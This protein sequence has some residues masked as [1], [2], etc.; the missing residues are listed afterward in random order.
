MTMMMTTMKLTTRTKII[1][2]TKIEII[3]LIRPIIIKINLVLMVPKAPMIKV[4]FHG[5]R[6]D[7]N[8]LELDQSLFYFIEKSICQRERLTQQLNEGVLE[9]LVCCERIKQREPV[10]NCSNCFHVLHL[11]CITKWAKSSKNGT[12]LSLFISH[13][14]FFPY[15]ILH[16]QF[17]R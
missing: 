9:C 3:N 8:H 17:L 12:Y 14:V 11:W 5:L 15:T 1:T 7:N 16:H 4:R 10:W 6:F 13:V 2:C